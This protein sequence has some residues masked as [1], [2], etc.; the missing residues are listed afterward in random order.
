MK[1]RG[2]KFKWIH[3]KILI[4]RWIKNRMRLLEIKLNTCNRYVLYSNLWNW[5]K[6]SRDKYFLCLI[7]VTWL[8]RYHHNGVF[9]KEEIEQNMWL[10]NF[11]Q[12][13]LKSNI[14]LRHSDQLIVYIMHSSTIILS[15]TH[16]HLLRF[17]F[18]GRA[19]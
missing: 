19:N 12:N 6:W 13:S 17:K 9:Q 3:S 15:S 11:K 2:L 8:G 14:T 10:Y 16:R 5:I 4:N 1:T 7:L 18:H